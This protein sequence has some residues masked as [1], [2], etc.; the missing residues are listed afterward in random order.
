MKG[1]YDITSQN[2]W[3]LLLYCNTWESQNK[4]T[5]W[6]RAA[7]VSKGLEMQY[8]VHRLAADRIALWKLAVPAP[9]STQLCL[10][11]VWVSC[12]CSSCPT[13]QFKNQL[14]SSSTFL[15]FKS[16]R[17]FLWQIHS[18]LQISFSQEKLLR[19]KC[20]HCN[21]P[22]LLLKLQIILNFIMFKR[23]MWSA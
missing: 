9:L 6:H 14:K 3:I 19:E 18:G 15:L 22:L 11:N 7:D 23:E 4:G 1:N 13:L 16:W 17:A 5:H 2:Y 8:R 21:N 20:W 12:V 10:L